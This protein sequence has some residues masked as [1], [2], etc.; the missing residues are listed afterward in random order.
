MD[1]SSL[2][3]ND[4]PKCEAI[5]LFKTHFWKFNTTGSENERDT[6]AHESAD[7]LAM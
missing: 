2:P 7:G 1:I 5:F 6:E 4:K 3:V